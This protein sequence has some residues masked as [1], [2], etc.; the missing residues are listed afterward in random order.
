MGQ[1][2]AQGPV[3]LSGTVEVPGVPLPFNRDKIRFRVFFYREIQA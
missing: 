1:E 2:I 3:E